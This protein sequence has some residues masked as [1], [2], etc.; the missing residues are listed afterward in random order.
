MKFVKVFL[1]AA[2]IFLVLG[3]LKNSIVQGILEVAI[4]KG[5]H[6][7]VHIGSTDLSFFKA[8]IE[9]KN[10]RVQNPPGFPEKNMIDIPQIFIKLD[11]A[12][13]RKGKLHFNDLRIHMEK[14]TVIKNKKGELNVNTLKSAKKAENKKPSKAPELMID[15]LS[16][17]IGQVIFKDYSAGGA[18]QVQTFDIQIKDRV[19]TRVSNPASI[20]SLIMFEALTRTSLARLADLDM[21]FFQSSAAGALAEGLGFAKDGAE[22]VTKTAKNIL[23]MFN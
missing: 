3:F 23:N 7:P 18:P 17:T 22:E 21:G 9:L 12:D 2:A 14:L 16:L 6:A 20:A 5:F 8:S 19:Y 15:R 4:S 13:L 11:P 1:I 10:I